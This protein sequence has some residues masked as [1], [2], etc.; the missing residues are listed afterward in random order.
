M[1]QKGTLY[2]QRSIIIA[3]VR[4]PQNLYCGTVEYLASARCDE[5][6]NISRAKKQEKV[7][8]KIIGWRMSHELDKL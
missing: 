5:S 2:R 4:W 6:K 3:V 1:L 8:R 7:G